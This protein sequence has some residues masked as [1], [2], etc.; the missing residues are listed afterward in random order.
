MSAPAIPN[1]D[2]A[3]FAARITANASL[4]PTGFLVVMMLLGGISLVSGIMFMVVGAWP[5]VPFLGLDVLLVWIAFRAYR[6]RSTA[7]EEVRVTRDELLVRR[8]DW[9]GREAEARFNPAW[10]RIE[11]TV[12]D[13]PQGLE[14]GLSHLAIGWKGKSILIAAD[15]SAPERLT[16][17]NALDKALADAR[18]A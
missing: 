4:G 13:P 11:K 12:F 8:V 17:A 14:G 18:R 2:T 6:K 15:L 5:V 7:Y 1:A 16:F 3:L 10:V 9:R